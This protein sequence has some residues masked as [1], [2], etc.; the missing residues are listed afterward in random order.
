MNKYVI[1][2]YIRLSVEDAKT[3]SLSIRHQ[4]LELTKFADRLP[5][6]DDAVILE[7]VDNGYSGTN[8]E[9]PAVQ[10]LLE[11]VQ[12]N[13]ID[14]IIVKDFTRFGRNAIET[15]YFIEMVFPLFRTRFISIQDDFDTNHFKED[16]GGMEVAFKY[17]ISEYYSKDLSEKSKSA[18]YQKMRA[19]EYQ[20]KIC[21]YGYKKGRDNRLEIDGD[22]AGV[23]RLIFDLSLNGHNAQQIV[24][25]LYRRGI[26]TPGEYKAQRGQNY[27]DVSRCY[28]LWQRSTVCRI[29]IDERYAGTYII[30][31]RAVKEIGGSRV[32]MKDESEW[33]KIPNH[34]PAIVD[35]ELFDRVQAGLLRFTSKKT[36]FKQYNL[37]GKIFCG[38]CG[39]A[40]YRRKKDAEF[41]CHFTRAAP[42]FACHGMSTSERELE[43]ML[44]EVMFKYAGA[45]LNIDGVDGFRELS[46]K[47]DQ[48]TGIERQIQDCNDHKRQ[49]YERFLLGE[50]DL[51]AYREQ[52]EVFDA[53]L[54][55]LNRLH[56]TL[57]S[58]AKKM[59]TESE[60]NAMLQKTA[61]D[62]TAESG[63]TRTLADKLIDRVYI[64]PGNRVEIVWKIRDFANTEFMPGI[65]A[66]YV[67]A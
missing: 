15:G 10:D 44:Y 36:N 32:R 39:H 42:D 26:P 62:I 9:R 64:Y 49:L 13:E 34:H 54:K 24:Q 65:G 40:L 31:K 58:M 33:F 59:Q 28:N 55:D 60:E 56:S 53:K 7:F 45:I 6:A 1:A 17:L 20:S 51:E 4:R 27:H 66:G 21:H 43:T 30:G 14:C 50:I 63:L 5:E 3:E 47:L 67:S 19:G 37:R 35:K 57:S 18:K 29:L 25:E 2:L 38:C 52:K 22:A 61:R 16:T 23:V 12:C 46:R 48:Q 41:Y 8:F 11:L